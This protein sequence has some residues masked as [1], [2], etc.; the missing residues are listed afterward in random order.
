MKAINLYGIE[1]GVTF[2]SLMNTDRIYSPV[3]YPEIFNIE[4]V[5]VEELGEDP[6][7]FIEEH[8]DEWNQYTIG[9][10]EYWNEH[11]ES[12]KK[13][14]VLETMRKNIDVFESQI[15]EQIGEVV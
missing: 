1:F 2:D 8:T 13:A 12:E 11:S 7:R 5:S 10:L 3:D 15:E 14:Y 4:V 6:L 9:I